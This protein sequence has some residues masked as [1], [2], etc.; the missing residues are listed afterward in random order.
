M[1]NP[2]IPLV[3]TVLPELIQELER[4]LTAAGYPELAQQATTL[5]LVE[6]CRCE[7]DFCATF[8]T[9]PKPWS[10][11]GSGGETIPLTDITDGMVSI[12][13]IQGQIV[14]V[15]VLFRDDIRRVLHEALP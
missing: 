3:S 13:L 6:R 8:L 9:A 4:S 1:D 7:D 5:R 2:S 14:M 11:L 15:E 10:A 12:D